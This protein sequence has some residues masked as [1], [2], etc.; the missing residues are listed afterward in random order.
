MSIATGYRNPDFLNAVCTPYPH[1]ICRATERV[2]E[3]VQS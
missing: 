3:R 2:T 1:P